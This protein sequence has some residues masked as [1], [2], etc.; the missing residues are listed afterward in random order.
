QVYFH[1]SFRESVAHLAMECTQIAAGDALLADAAA[2]YQSSWP[3]SPRRRTI[4]AS[5]GLRI[6]NCSASSGSVMLP[7]A[8]CA[9][10]CY[11][12]ADTGF[13][14]SWRPGRATRKG[15]EAFSSAPV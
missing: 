5:Q 8:A 12:S 3:V 15:G 9:R 11:R 14:S 1:L 7:E 13:I 4:S 2:F 10:T 6:R